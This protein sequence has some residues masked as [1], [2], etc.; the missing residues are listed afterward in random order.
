MGSPFDDQAAEYLVL[1]NGE[2]QHSLWPASLRPPD[3]WRTGFGPAGRDDCLTYVNDA[4]RDLRPRSLAVKADPPASRGQEFLCAFDRGELEGSFGRWHTLVNGWRVTGELDLPALQLALDDLVARHEALRTEIVHYDGQAHQRIQP[5]S[6][7][8]LVVRDL[9]GSQPR[10][11]AAETLLNEVD[12]EPFGLGRLPHIRA[13]VGRFDQTDAMLV[14]ATHHSATDYWSMQVL[15]RDLAMLYAARVGRPAG[16]LPPAPQY[17]EYAAWQRATEDSPLVRQARAYWREQLRG[18]ELLAIPTD[19]P[20][21]R[22]VPN[23]YGVHRFIAAADVT[24]AAR[25]LA[26]S[27]RSTPF[28]VLLAAYQLLLYRRTGVTDLV[29]PTFTAGR[30]AR[31]QDT[32][33]IFFN[34]MPL[35][36]DLT[37]CATL[38]EL[39]ARTRSTC[40]QAQAHDIPFPLIADEAPG[41][42]RQLAL[43]DRTVVTFELLQYGANV[44][45]IRVGGLTITELRRRVRSQTS[46]SHIPDGGLWAMDLLPDGELAGSLKYNRNLLDES[47]VVDFTSEYCEVLRALVAEPDRAPQDLSG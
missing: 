26:R 45:T 44:D 7:P 32:V 42:G 34:F 46:S 3:G 15:V 28:M 47:T 31:F 39:I 1:V 12:A 8:E 25:Q 17:R 33:G 43:D 27:T 18:A 9:D 14:L 19:R 6:S 29:V 23:T 37:G 41:I 2:G 40:L 4:W 16:D 13:V 38:R 35:R 20:R 21:P 24:A 11:A 10:E 5:P 36:T 22:G 30:D